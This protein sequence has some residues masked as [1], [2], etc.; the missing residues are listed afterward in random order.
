MFLR[1][2]RQAEVLGKRTVTARLTNP[3]FELLEELPSS[4][5]VGLSSYK[6]R[7]AQAGTFVLLRIIPGTAVANPEAIAADVRHGM[8]DNEPLNSP[9]AAR[10]VD[11]SRDAATGEIYIATEYVR[12]ITLR[13]RIRRVAPFSLTVATEIAAAIADTVAAAHRSGVV[14]GALSPSCVILS[15]DSKARVSDF[16][17]SR[18]AHGAFSQ[19]GPAGLERYMDPATRRDAPRSGDDIFALGIVLFE[20]LTGSTPLPGEK[21]ISARNANASVP[22][23]LEGIIQK[24]THPNASLRYR[25]MGQMLDDLQEVSEALKAG[26]PLTWSPLTGKP[27]RTP[28]PGRAESAGSLTAAAA[29][30]EQ[31]REIRYKEPA[32]A[33]TIAVRVLFV[34]VVLGVIGLGYQ[35]AKFLAVPNNV[36]V[37][38]LIGKTVDDSRAIAKQ[39]GF[40][41]VEG[42]SDY[43]TKW[44]ENQIYKQDP[45]NGTEIKAGRPV[46]YFRSLGP[47]LITVPDL[48]GMTKERAAQ[49]LQD[50]GLPP[51]AIDEQY[52]GSVQKGVVITQ[53]L[54]SGT[55]T[56]RGT[57]VSLS[58]SK[59]PQP[60]DTPRDVQASPA[61]PAQVD[62]TW[63]AA[64]RALTY[65]VN[66]IEDG[67]PNVIASGLK[68]T[69]F[70]DTTVKP[71]SSYSYTV[72]AVNAAGDSDPSE[73]ALAIT[74]PVVT[75]SPTMPDT[76]NLTPPQDTS[77]DT[78]GAA[79]GNKQTQMRQFEIAFRVPR[80]P[81]GDRHVQ[82]EVQ[83]ATG[84]TL[85]YDEHHPS[86]A[87]IDAPVTAFG[88]KVMF[89]I[90]VDGKLV[91]QKTL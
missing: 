34:I 60:P 46:T 41:L 9:G 6:A 57:V 58:V 89:R 81:R 38:N 12:G 2:A 40:E 77:G 55:N 79:D 76:V 16:G 45:P 30:L 59:G 74:P 32:S 65:N 10:I 14:H 13:E 88:N 91:K 19:E 68:S 75:S 20:M 42:G 1:G 4:N 17:L 62:V 56:A 8:Q 36:V 37:P 28:R 5:P 87:P 61:G 39:Q 47:R 49:A 86:G 31:E 25:D 85:V 35:G 3:R 64:D 7:D 73:P 52:S 66:R 21:T 72:S 90:F 78:P 63:S 11:G 43:S 84:T 67:T 29:E 83:D 82:F 33:L 23:A 70:T 54:P 44:P 27:A 48:K 71:S 24:A 80:R 53:S 51:P 18:A 22:T 15:P 69:Q 50:A 26:R